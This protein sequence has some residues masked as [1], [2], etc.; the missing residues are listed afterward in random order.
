[1]TDTVTEV[2]CRNCR[3]WVG[4]TVAPLVPVET[5]AAGEES[6]IAPPRDLR[7]CRSCGTV[8]VFI[9]R[10]DLDLRRSAALASG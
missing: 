8:T 10:A 2:R 5:V 6:K 1:M 4:E 9:P 3:K 7:L